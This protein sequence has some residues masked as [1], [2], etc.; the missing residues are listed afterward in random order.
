MAASEQ[1]S[2]DSIS[3]EIDGC[4]DFQD[5]LTE[6]VDFCRFEALNSSVCNFISFNPFPLL[7][8]SI[9]E[10]VLSRTLLFSG[11]FLGGELGDPDDSD[12]AKGATM[13]PVRFCG[14]EEYF[15]ISL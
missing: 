1:L 7:S 3:V 9:V 10:D 8:K 13:K 14:R 11:I 4:S 2:L 15:R 12:P 5:F 6:A